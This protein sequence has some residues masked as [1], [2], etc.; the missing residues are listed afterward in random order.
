MNSDA[1]TLTNEYSSMIL[2]PVLFFKFFH[3]YEDI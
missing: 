2:N 1:Y 3:Y